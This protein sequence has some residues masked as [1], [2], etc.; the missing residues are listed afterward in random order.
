MD[1]KPTEKRKVS[2]GTLTPRFAVQK[3][4]CDPTVPKSPPAV[5]KGDEGAG[6]GRNSNQVPATGVAKPVPRPPTQQAPCTAEIKTIGAFP[7]LM[8]AVSWDAVGSLNSRNGAPSFP[9][10]LD[11]VFSDKPRDSVFMSSGYKDLPI[12]QGSVQKLS[13]LREVNQWFSR[14]H[15][16]LT[17]HLLYLNLP[18]VKCWK[19]KIKMICPYVCLCVQEH[20]LMRNQSI[21][22]S[23]LP[24]LSETVEQEKGDIL[25][26]SCPCKTKKYFQGVYFLM[27][28]GKFEN[29]LLD[30]F[31]FVPPIYC[32]H[33]SRK[34]NAVYISHQQMAWLLSH[35]C[36][37][38]LNELR[39]LYYGSL[40]FGKI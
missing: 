30:F 12:Q 40:C 1:W 33:H 36:Q 5:N 26:P 38:P 28:G 2:S 11:E 24:D 27:L 4:N 14:L 20:K 13:K 21:G 22:G 7:P 15:V 35:V 39:K 32:Q 6:S 31:F 29:D 10:T 23:K 25:V 8:R 18:L 9:P 3:E 37:R 17:I 19:S 34:R 16:T